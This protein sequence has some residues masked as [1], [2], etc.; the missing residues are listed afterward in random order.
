M[1]LLA[2][3]EMIGIGCVS[4]S[5]VSASGLG[6]RA[7][8]NAD[9]TGRACGLRSSLTP[10]PGRGKAAGSSG[11]A[12][13]SCA[14]AR[15]GEASIAACMRCSKESGS[16]RGGTRGTG[17]GRSRSVAPGTRRDSGG[18]RP[19]SPMR[20]NPLRPACG[21]TRSPRDSAAHDVP[22]FKLNDLLSRS[23]G[24]T[25]AQRSG[26]GAAD[27][28]PIDALGGSAGLSAAGRR[29]R[30]VRRPELRRWPV[31]MSREPE[32]RRRLSRPGGGRLVVWQIR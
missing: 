18:T 22:L 25:N 28:R 7:C 23:N 26:S 13:L 20:P 16:L 2:D 14:A 8:K 32:L 5:G 30:R 3:A 12:A 11:H 19:S 10:G 24:V 4:G 29:L 6:M 17:F 1:S 27:S 31:H 21:V 15:S 9:G